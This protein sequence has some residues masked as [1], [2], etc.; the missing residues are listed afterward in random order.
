M[1]RPKMEYAAVVSSPQKKKK[2][3]DKEIRK[4]TEGGDKDGARVERQAMQENLKK[5]DYQHHRREE[6]RGDLITLYKIVKMERINR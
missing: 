5:S 4:N 1:I 3:K 2:K 6:L